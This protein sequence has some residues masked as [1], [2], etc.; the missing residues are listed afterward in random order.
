MN[1]TEQI[2]MNNQYLEVLYFDIYTYIIY[3]RKIEDICAS[4]YE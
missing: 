2:C 3:N 1:Y 4:D